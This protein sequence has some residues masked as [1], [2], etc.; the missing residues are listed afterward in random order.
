[1]FKQLA[2]YFCLSAVLADIKLQDCSDLQTN[3][4]TFRVY[5]QGNQDGILN[6]IFNVI[7]VNTRIA[8]R[9]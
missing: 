8:V 5:S 3:N 4:H 2:F 9:L 7:G 6:A 1:M